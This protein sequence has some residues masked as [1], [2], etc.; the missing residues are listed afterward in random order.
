MRL[1]TNHE[2]NH[3]KHD[4]CIAIPFLKHRLSSPSG[5]ERG[6]RKLLF[7][8]DVLSSRRERRRSCNPGNE[9]EIERTE[10]PTL[11]SSL[12]TAGLAMAKFCESAFL[13]IV[14]PFRTSRRRQSED[15]P[16]KPAPPYEISRG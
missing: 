1:L 16:Q 11:T 5:R 8:P 13:S 7:L 3:G 6:R 4:R 9:N 14:N 2:G 10:A 12:W 15:L